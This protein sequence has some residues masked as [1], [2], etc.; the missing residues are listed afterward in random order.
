MAYMYPNVDSRDLYGPLAEKRTYEELKGLSNEYSI[1]HSVHWMK[2]NERTNHISWFENDYVILH[3]RFGILVLDVKGGEIRWE[4]GVMVQKNQQNG[5]EKYLNNGNDPL[6]QAIR[7]VKDNYTHKIKAIIPDFEEKMVIEPL[8]FLPEYNLTESEINKMPQNYKDASFAILDHSAFGMFSRKIDGVF[9][10]Y[11]ADTKVGLNDAEFEKVKSLIAPTF[12]LKYSPSMLKS[13]LENQFIR[14][15]SEQAHLIDYIAEQDVATIQGAAGTGKTSVAIEAAKTF[16]EEG[17][18]VLYLCFNKFLKEFLEKSY[19]S[20]ENI[21]FCNIHS[22]IA[23]F[24]KRDTRKVN[25][26]IAALLSINDSMFDY[27]DIIIDEAQDFENDEIEYFK[28]YVQLKGGHFFAFFDKNQLV[29]KKEMPEWLEHSECKLVLTRN[30]RNTRQIAKTSY[31]FVNAKINPKY[32]MIEGT[33]DPRMVFAKG[34]LKTQLAQLISYYKKKGYSY[35]EITILTLGTEERSI[36]KGVSKIGSVN[37][38]SAAKPG[39]VQFTTAAK[40]KGL[41]S[42]IVII[43]DIFADCFTDQRLLNDFYV[44]SSRAKHHLAL[45]IDANDEE[46]I[47]KISDAIDPDSD[48]TEENTILMKTQTKQLKF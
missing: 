1:F 13:S 42:N 19:A 12:D 8:I 10:K 5:I 33:E 40:F 44:A 26:R 25:D 48:F 15:T 3:K 28:I 39:S 41:E 2:N 37:I 18:K 43:I 24:S 23:K 27:D 31:N 21:E 38:S 34:D 36:L 32:R 30:C 45:F 17:R 11:Y 14:F 47:A 6:A 16:A 35:D 4:D 46:T 9:K 20:E 22:F 29:L 7:A